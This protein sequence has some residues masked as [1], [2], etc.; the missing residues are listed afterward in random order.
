[1]HIKHGQIDAP[2]YAR[3]GLFAWGLNLISLFRAS[4]Q[5]SYSKTKP[6]HHKDL[7]Y[8][9]VEWFPY[10]PCAA[11]IKFPAEAAHSLAVWLPRSVKAR[12]LTQLFHIVAFSMLLNLEIL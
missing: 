2:P 9:E 7:N 12:G 5:L 4:I 6:Q 3:E 10:L 8:K 1:V 11:M